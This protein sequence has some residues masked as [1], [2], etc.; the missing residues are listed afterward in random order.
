MVVQR[1][2]RNHD[3]MGCQPEDV[4]DEREARQS[5]EVGYPPVVGEGLRVGL[6]HGV[7][8][9]LLVAVG[10]ERAARDCDV[11]DFRPVAVEMLV[12]QSCGVMDYPPWAGEDRRME[13][14]T[15]DSAEG[16]WVVDSAWWMGSRSAGSTG[17]Q[18]WRAR[19]CR[20]LF[21]LRHL[22]RGRDDGVHVSRG[23]LRGCR[24]H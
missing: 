15:A 8:D 11:G 2:G 14:C 23:K 13:G 3:V 1:V 22:P 16:S 12:G 10:E 6:P 21:F 17:E 5:D 9:F 19:R 20:F 7:V 24:N 18:T 4:V